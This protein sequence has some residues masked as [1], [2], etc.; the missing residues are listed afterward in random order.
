MLPGTGS[1]EA[2]LRLRSSLGGR[3]E[4]TGC[5][6]G[7]RGGIRHGLL[8]LRQRMLHL[9]PSPAAAPLNKVS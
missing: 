5:K 4:S 7:E 2:E 3:S 6:A 1:G 9:S 8:K